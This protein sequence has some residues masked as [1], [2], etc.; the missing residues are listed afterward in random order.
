MGFKKSYSENGVYAHLNSSANTTITTGDTFVAIQ[1][2]FTNSPIKNFALESGSIVCKNSAFNYYE[3]DWHATLSSQ[4]AG[5]T[6]H[7]GIAIN[8]ETLLISSTS[9]MG[10][11]CKYAGEPLPLSGT[12]VVQLSYDST[13]QLQTTSNTDAD[14]VTFDHFT[15]TIREFYI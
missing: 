13:I 1:G 6:I 8:G 12:L 5:R 14:V 2:V 11:F 15:T 3:I 7:V 4:D 9:V 10:V